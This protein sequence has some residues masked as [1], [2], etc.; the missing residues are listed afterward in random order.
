MAVAVAVL[1][2]QVLHQLVVQASHPQLLA[3]RLLVVA[4]VVVV[5]VLVVLVVAVQALAQAQTEQPIQV[6]V[7]VELAQYPMVNQEGMVVQELLSCVH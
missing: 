1:V 4:V 2:L 6:V 3:H 7:A 5:T